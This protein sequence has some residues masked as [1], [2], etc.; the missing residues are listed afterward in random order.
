VTRAVPLDVE[1]TK[2]PVD[3]RRL[4][5]LVAGVAVGCVGGYLVSLPRSTAA[6]VSSSS[7]AGDRGVEIRLDGA[8]ATSP[9]KESLPSGLF[10][11]DLRCRCKT[12][13]RIAVSVVATG[14]KVPLLESARAR[15]TSLWLGSTR[16]GQYDLSVTAQG[17]WTAAI[18]D[19][20]WATARSVPITA[21]GTGPAIIGP[22][23]F[24]GALQLY[25]EAEPAAFGGVSRF[26]IENTLSYLYV[27]RSGNGSE[28]L[29]ANT[30][31]PT[32]AD[33]PTLSFPVIS[34]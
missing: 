9:S 8:S 11:A 26:V 31:P 22:I 15:G 25:D 19:E 2:P 7:A 28:A 29:V 30:S 24:R 13:P 17:P 10:S 6:T 32:S 33:G 3:L 14:I 20:P 27:T 34:V 5:Q 4:G 12:P 16:S 23:R 21:H 18:S 1:K